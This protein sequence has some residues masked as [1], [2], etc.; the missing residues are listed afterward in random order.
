MRI[1]LR[2]G[3]RTFEI[4][5]FADGNASRT[6]SDVASARAFLSRFRGDVSAMNKLR[7]F[8][9]HLS[10]MDVS[11]GGDER[12]LA[13]VAAAFASGRIHL[14]GAPV[15][16][17]TLSGPG[18]EIAPEPPAPAPPPRAAA[19]SAPPNEPSMFDPDFDAAAQ[20]AV[21]K[22]ASESG[23]PFCEECE[24]RRREAAAA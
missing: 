2:Q 8:A 10:G 1:T 12:V 21:L 20:A 14:A 19:S 18:A 22:E 16:R 11:R 5:K 4:C 9:S 13:T 7:H 23:V 15:R 24:R 6:F 3:P 17:S